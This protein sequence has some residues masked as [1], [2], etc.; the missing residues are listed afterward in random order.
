MGRERGEDS[1]KPYVFLSHLWFPALVSSEFSNCIL[2][3]ASSV[4]YVTL[5]CIAP[6]TLRPHTHQILSIPDSKLDVQQD[7]G[8]GLGCVGQRLTGASSH[9]S[10]LP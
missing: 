5:H 1:Y 7:L 2:H 10:Q 3:F 9:G 8:E 6:Q 4:H